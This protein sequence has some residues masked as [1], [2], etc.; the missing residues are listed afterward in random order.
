MCFINSSWSSQRPA[1]GW[2]DWLGLFRGTR[3]PDILILRFSLRVVQDLVSEASSDFGSRNNVVTPRMS[4]QSLINDAAC[5]NPNVNVIALLERLHETTCAEAV[6]F[7]GDMA[8]ADIAARV[9]ASAN[10]SGE[11][12]RRAYRRKSAAHR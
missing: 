10:I 2:S 3:C 1:V 5:H 6:H 12:S 7:Y 11:I 4:H 8:V 9:S